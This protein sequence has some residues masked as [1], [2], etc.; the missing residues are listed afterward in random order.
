MTTDAGAERLKRA[1]QAIRTVTLAFGQ[2][3]TSA[4]E[5][6][7]AAWEFGVLMRSLDPETWR[8]GRIM[9]AGTAWERKWKRK[10]QVTPSVEVSSIDL[11][12]P[13]PAWWSRETP[14][15]RFETM[16]FGGALDRLS[17]RTETREEIEYI[18]EMLCRVCVVCAW[19][20]QRWRWWM[21]DKVFGGDV[22]DTVVSP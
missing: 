1:T 15:D 11:V 22:L 16:V 20:P 12:W 7:L 8:E 10:T 3:A 2:V 13:T 9:E 6:G 5:A 4:R 14:A 21:V 17:F 18:H 19:V